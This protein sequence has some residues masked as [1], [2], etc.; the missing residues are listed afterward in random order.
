MNGRI[1]KINRIP[2][3][4]I[5]I[6]VTCILIYLYGSGEKSAAYNI[7][8]NQN[9]VNMRKLLIGAIH[10]AQRG[11]LEIVEVAQS[12]DLKERSKGKTDEGAN[13]PYTVADSRSHCVMKQGLLRIFPRIVVISE[14][15]KEICTESS[16]FDLD[17]TVLHET[18]KVTDELVS[19]HDITIW[20]D[21]LDAT[22]EFTEKLYQYVTT[23]VCVAVKG[24][25]VIGVIHNP[26]SG[27]T[28]WAWLGHSMSEYLETIR[29]S[30]ATA[31]QPVITVSR[32]HAGNA[33]DLIY[34]VFGEHSNIL[35]AAGAG[36][37]VLQVIGNN[38]TAYLHSTKIKKWDICAGDAILRTFGGR[39][40]T[41]DNEVINYGRNESAI[42][43]R[44]LLATVSNHEQYIDKIIAYRQATNVKSN[45]R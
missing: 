5:V 45:Q 35:T 2:V 43:A 25:P 39:M 17:P 8:T 23:M 16:T 44:G 9:K 19:V 11:G 4:I 15:D 13:D 7:F 34:A 33:K 32:S 30:A 22:Q 10:A 29:L 41:L 3:S 14:E 28:A 1:I 20:I 6:I 27:Q 12:Q 26:F 37:K 36:Y 38:A 31:K 40:T 42:N 24:N 18:A 21:P